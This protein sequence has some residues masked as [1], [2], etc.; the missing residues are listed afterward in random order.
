MAALFNGRDPMPAQF[1]E[2]QEL[3]IQL[4]F[5]G[6]NNFRELGGYPL[7]DGGKVKLGRLFRSDHLAKMTDA[8]LRKMDALGVKT[9]IDLRR[10]SEREDSP[11]RIE[12]PAIQQI[13]LPVRAEG[14]D[15]RKLRLSLEQGSISAADAENYLIQANLEF[16]RQFAAVYARF[17]EYLLDEANYPIVFHCTAGKDR[18][19]F[20]AALSLLAAGASMETVF[21]DYLAT[22]R[23]TAHYV[24]GIIDG[25]EDMPTMKASPDAVRALMQVKRE[26]L[27]TAF[28]T[29][30]QDYDS[31]DA[32]FEVALKLGP[33]QRARVRELLCE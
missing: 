2:L 8:D 23:C 29:I 15:V 19:G 31:L 22:N 33:D 32:F 6:P 5:D 4:E 3:P 7:A 14:A 12:N 16:V 28:N 10:Q 18:A 26:Y 20:A 13:W 24:N 9:V 25:L 1:S 21:H 30:D 17:F 27:Q 11:D